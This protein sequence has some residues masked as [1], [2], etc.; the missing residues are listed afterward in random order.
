MIKYI[1]IS[2]FYL[3][4]SF[5]YAKPICSLLWLND[6]NP[7]A[8]L[9]INFDDNTSGKYPLVL[10]VGGPSKAIYSYSENMEDIVDVYGSYRYWIQ[11]D[12][13]WRNVSSAIK[14]RISSTLEPAQY[15]TLDAKTVMDKNS[16]TTW[17]TFGCRKIN[18]TY[19]FPTT[20]LN[21]LFLEI[22]TTNITPGIYKLP[23]PVKVAYEEN[24][25]LYD[26]GWPRFSF[27]M[28]AAP[29]VSSN[30]NLYVKPKCELLSENLSVNMG[31]S[32]TPAQANSGVHKKVNI[33]IKCNH[34]ATVKWSLKGSPIIDG[35]S[36]R[37][38]CGTGYCELNF[39]NNN[40]EIQT[41]SPEGISTQ[42]INVLYKDSNAKEGPF[43][44]SAVLSVEVV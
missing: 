34:T 43:S 19:T 17:H 37:T 22:I 14:Y 36:N 40:G 26:D 32:I 15:Q 39:N 9:N 16:Y 35:V 20:T 4:S 1:I 38:T 12:D 41:S 30:V 29:T 28:S 23:L 8:E 33:S 25:G 27:L 31:N 5:L 21:G 24:K 3:T 13:S 44:G 10:N 18:E 6:N 42:E 11:Y 7:T 2:V